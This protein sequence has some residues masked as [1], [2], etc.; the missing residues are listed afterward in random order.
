MPDER[1][2]PEV[3]WEMVV[4]W[5][6]EDKLWL[7][8]RALSATELDLMAQFPGGRH[9]LTLT[10]AEIRQALDELERSA[11]EIERL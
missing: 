10:F 1:R 2:T 11:K 4:R 8:L 5:K 9:S 6:D 7:E 3:S